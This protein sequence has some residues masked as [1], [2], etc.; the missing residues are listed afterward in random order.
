MGVLIDSMSLES[1]FDGDSHAVVRYGAGE[2]FE[3]CVGTFADLAEASEYAD[4][5][6]QIA[7]GT[8]RTYRV[9]SIDK[10]GGG[11]E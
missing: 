2:K 9:V 11:D 3:K 5:M 8:G 6:N 7:L 10:V 4:S 1:L